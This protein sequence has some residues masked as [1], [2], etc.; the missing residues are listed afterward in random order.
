MW[1]SPPFFRSFFLLSNS[2]FLTFLLNSP[3]TQTFTTSTHNTYM[4]EFS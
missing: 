3:N 2:F 1:L 4:H